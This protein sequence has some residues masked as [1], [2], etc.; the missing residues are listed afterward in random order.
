MDAQLSLRIIKGVSGLH[1][2][3]WILFALMTVALIGVVVL[4]FLKEPDAEQPHADLALSSVY[5]AQLSEI[6]A[7]VDRGTIN[8]EEAEAL[9]AEVARRLLAQDD[10]SSDPLAT[11]HSDSS[12]VRW[13]VWSIV[14]L[15]P[16]LA[17]GTYLNFGSPLLPSQPHAA[18]QNQAS[19]GVR[20]TEL[21]R[22]I[23]AQLA[24]HP[25]D[26]RG[27]D[28]I[29]PVYMRTGRYG[30]AALAWRNAGRLL[31]ET[32]ERVLGYAEAEVFAGNGI[33]SEE[34]R[35]ALRR[36]VALRPD[37][38]PA[39][40]WL[41]IARKQDGDLVPA[42]K[43]LIALLDK[44]GETTL[45]GRTITDHIQD[46]DARL[47]RNDGKGASSLSPLD[48]E[49]ETRARIEGMV[50]GLA[51]RLHQD[52]SDFE[53]WL[54]LIRSYAV[55]KR[56]DD[57]KAALQKTQ[58]LFSGDQVKLDRLKALAAELKLGS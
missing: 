13:A 55:L 20:V 9:R 46:I 28:V 14:G 53:G 37:Y 19:D 50:S 22:R 10:N 24:K 58:S 57:A 8:A 39:Q 38:L 29:A 35:L 2:L 49:V 5:K 31:G 32:P 21:V 40:F 30:D 1:M 41:A 34:A 48:S 47:A 51:D 56:P 23:E 52:A 15:V 7:D 43:D 17:L 33:V 54:R 16:V 3:L 27:W 12:S 26:G 42:R 45:L 25:E 6:E 4:P 36:G 11:S 18:R 44:A